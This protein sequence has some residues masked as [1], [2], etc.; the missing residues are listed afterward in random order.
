MNKVKVKS[1]EHKIYNKTE[2]KAIPI[3]KRNEFIKSLNDHSFLKPLCFVMMFAGLRTG[4]TLAL[5]WK[6][7][8]F[9]NKN[10]KVERAITIVPKF[11]SNGKLISRKTVIGDTKTICS[12]RVVP[13][14]DILVYALKEYYD[15]QKEK[16]SQYNFDFVDKESLYLVIMMAK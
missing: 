7:I 16:S 1:Q 9:E 10:I 12:K 8:D 15:L 2:Y 14:P 13:M 5:Q 6:D 11:D 4:E 3:E